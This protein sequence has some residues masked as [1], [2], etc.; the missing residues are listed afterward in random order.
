MTTPANVQPSKTLVFLQAALFA[1]WPPLTFAAGNLGEAFDGRSVALLWAAGLVLLLVL[2]GAAATVAPA[3]SRVIFNVFCVLYLVLFTYGAIDGFLKSEWFVERARWSLAVWA[4]SCVVAA[5]L[6]WRLFRSA[7]A[8][9]VLL[10]AVTAM[11]LSSA[12]SLA[13]RL[14][15]TGEA[16]DG[17]AS[18]AASDGADFDGGAQQPDIFAFVLDGY[19]RSDNLW[20]GLGIDNRE[21]L[22]RLS[23]FGFTTLPG[24]FANY[25]I[26]TLSISSALNMDYLVEP[27]PRALENYVRFQNLLSGYNPVVRAMKGRGYEFLQIPPGNWAGTDCRGVQDLCIRSASWGVNETQITLL[28]MTPAEIVIRRFFGGVLNFKRMKFPEAV[29]RIVDHARREPKPVF[30]FA[31]LMIP[32]DPIYTANC[33]ERDYSPYFEEALSPARRG[34]YAETIRCLNRQIV[35][36]LPDL[37]NVG[38]KPIVLL[39]S[40]HGITFGDMFKRE[41]S[42]WTAD[43]IRDRFG[44]LI[45]IRVPERCRQHLYPSMSLVNS[46]RFVLGCIDGKPPEFVR[47]RMFLS[48]YGGLEVVERRVGSRD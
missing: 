36:N 22:E 46:F 27:G 34:E 33:G 8:S 18:D 21:F 9:G 16:T 31:H 38:R 35:E 5:C 1:A 13:A 44:N 4:A 43:E 30:A 47:D 2:G 3:R 6:I 11:C 37:F 40:D 7:A 12:V 15:A 10:I 20:T 39:L 23:K 48:K 28:Q 14:V 19:G 17:S 41:I 24:S 29:I 26:T 32:H 42:E 25:P 45:S